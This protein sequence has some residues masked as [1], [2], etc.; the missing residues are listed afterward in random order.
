MEFRR[1]HHRRELQDRIQGQVCSSAPAYNCANTNGARL[2]SKA[3]ISKLV[4]LGAS[5]TL[6]IAL[7]ATENGKA[8]RPH[9]AFLLLQD[10]DTGLETT[11]PFTVKETGKAKV[12]F[13]CPGP[14]LTATWF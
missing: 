2:S 13:V 6:K 7:T 11:F 9:Q 1:R 4:S 8:K 3:A 5:E 12:D 14:Q 10:Q